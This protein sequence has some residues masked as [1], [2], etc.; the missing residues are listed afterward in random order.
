MCQR[1]RTLGIAIGATLLLAQTVLAEA[2]RGIAVNFDPALSALFQSTYG[3]DEAGVLRS[4]ILT[5]LTNEA[6]HAAIPDGLT[7]KVT[8]RKVLPTHPT[9]KQ[10]LDN[11][12]LSPARTRYLGGADLVGEL[13]D[14]KQQVVATVDYRKFADVMAAG[15]PSLDPWADARQAIDG[16]A[17]KLAAT[18]DKLPL[19]QPRS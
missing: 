11:P 10:Q 18:W 3:A 13:R 17:A 5:A 19:N 12:S 6:S 7:L 2:S 14:S 4:A 15:S 16:F 8:V 9:M 1:L